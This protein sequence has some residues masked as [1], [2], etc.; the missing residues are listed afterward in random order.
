MRIV[1]GDM[2]GRALA[3][4]RSSAIRPTTDRTREAVFNVIAHSY[5]EH[6]EGVRVLDLFAGTGALGLEA[7]SRGASYCVFVEESAEGRGL[8]RT[9][10]ETFGLQG[11]TKIFRRDATTLG[12]AGTLQPFK[13]VFAD[14]PY[15]KG[16]GELALAEA[17]KGGWLEPDALIVVEE[18]SATPFQPV[19]GLK[20]VDRRDYGDTTVTFCRN[21]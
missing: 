13:L 18:A 10:V 20:L 4:P 7:L 12:S 8:I 16:F 2:R 11:R 19:A 15:G 9:N 3:T 14:P 21:A 1:G 17:I 5:P 6:L